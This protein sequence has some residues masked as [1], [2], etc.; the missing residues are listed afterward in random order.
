MKNADKLMKF[1]SRIN[2]RHINNICIWFQDSLQVPL[3]VL[4]SVIIDLFV[5]RVPQVKV[6]TPGDF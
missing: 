3:K 1:T 2:F 5:N 4:L 6:R